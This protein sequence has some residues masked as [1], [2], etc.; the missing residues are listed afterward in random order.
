LVELLLLPIAKVNLELLVIGEALKVLWSILSEH[1]GFNNKRS[2][3]EANIPNTLLSSERRRL[4]SSLD[5]MVR[6][7][8]VSIVQSHYSVRILERVFEISVK[9]LGSC[10]EISHP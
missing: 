2:N 6:R 7:V 3:E 10:L 8:R 5:D 1:I 9:D 4:I